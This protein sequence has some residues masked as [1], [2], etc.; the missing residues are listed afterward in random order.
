MTENTKSEYINGIPIKTIV[1]NQKER[2]T[3]M[4]TKKA[5]LITGVFILMGSFLFAQDYMYI[6]AKKC[7]MCHNSEKS[8]YQYKIWSEKK[9]SQALASL[10]SPESWEYAKANGI[11]DPNKEKSCLKCH[12]TFHAVAEDAI[13]TLQASEG[14]SCESCHGPGSKYKSMTI[15]K[16]REKSLANGLILPTKEVC[17]SCHNEDNPFYKPFNFEEAVKKIAHPTPK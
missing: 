7:K 5:L 10:D 15:M 12:S 1:I 6:G 4:I 11:A 8:G 2:N 14:V 9:H 3:S 17:V 16:S 13:L